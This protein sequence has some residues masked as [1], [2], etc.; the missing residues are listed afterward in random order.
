MNHHDEHY[1]HLKLFY[2]FFYY[3]LKNIHILSDMDGVESQ[4]LGK[5]AQYCV[6]NVNITGCTV[7]GKPI[8]V[9]GGMNLKINEFVK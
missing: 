9:E 3:L 1:K 2:I 7:Q 5:D 8:S 4:I 6:R